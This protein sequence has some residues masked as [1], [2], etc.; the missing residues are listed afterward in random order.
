IAALQQHYCLPLGQFIELKLIEC[1][2]SALDCYRLVPS[3]SLQIWHAKASDSGAYRCMAF[4]PFL[5]VRMF[6]HYSVTLK[7]VKPRHAHHMRDLHFVVKPKEI[8]SSIL[9]SNITIECVANGHPNP[10]ISWKRI[11]SK[12]PKER[13][14]EDNGNLHLTTLEKGDEGTYVCHAISDKGSISASTSLEVSEIPQI[15]NNE[16]YEVLDIGE[17]QDLELA[18]EAKGFPK[19]FITWLHN[20]YIMDSKDLSSNAFEFNS[21]E[22]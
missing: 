12:L 18:C 13:F 22:T 1:I 15:V 8:T 10:Q 11:G 17:G 3:G 19:P 5:S 9:G 6:A 7:V 2:F 4:N 20:G 14:M 21:D 16:P